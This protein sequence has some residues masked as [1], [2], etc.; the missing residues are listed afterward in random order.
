MAI[1]LN[2]LAR[3]YDAQERYAE[4]ETLYLQALEL[5][6]HL[7]GKEHPNIANCLNNLAFIYA[8]Q[9]YQLKAETTYNQAL[10]EGGDKC[11]GIPPKEVN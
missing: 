9:G 10:E 1:S 4:A 3:L 5:F 6:K 8:Q 2:N 7:L 11:K